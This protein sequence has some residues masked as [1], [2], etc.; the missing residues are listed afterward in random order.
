[1][2]SP[3]WPLGQYG[4]S[5]H[6]MAASRGFQ[7]SAGHAAFGNAHRIAPVH[8]Q[9][10]QNGSQLRYIFMSLSILSSTITVA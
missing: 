2:L 8:L 5:S 7:C 1:L 4:A 6:L 10:L 3:W 9:G